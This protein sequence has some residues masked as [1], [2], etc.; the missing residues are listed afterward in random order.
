MRVANIFIKSDTCSSI[1]AG[2]IW[3]YYVCIILSEIRD[4]IVQGRELNS[5][6]SIIHYI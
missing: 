5:V 3:K 1:F 6:E 2:V 4:L